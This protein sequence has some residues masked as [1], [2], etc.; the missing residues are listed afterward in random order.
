MSRTLAEMV[1]TARSEAREISPAQA[2]EADNRSELALTVDVREPSEYE[3]SRLPGAITIPRGGLELR[4]DPTSPVAD[5]ALSADP[6]G[7][8][9]IAPRVQV[10]ARCSPRRH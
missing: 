1:A 7:S 3:Q 6:H 10:H 2:A 5:A 4:D 9:C 8:S